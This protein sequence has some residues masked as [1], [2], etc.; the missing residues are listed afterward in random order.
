M[1]PG[2]KPYLLMNWFEFAREFK[3]GSRDR[4]SAADYQELERVE[5]R[6]NSPVPENLK[7]H[8]MEIP[9]TYKVQGEYK[10]NSG[11]VYFMD[12][13]HPQHN[14]LSAYGWVKRGEEREIKS[15]SGRQRLNI[16]GAIDIETMSCATVIDA[17]VMPIR[18]SCCCG[19]SNQ[20][21]FKQT[22][23]T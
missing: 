12:G 10:N 2:C 7:I 23:S 6:P 14:T 19:N 11:L 1:S 16:N 13:V 22:L 4:L 15:N 20:D 17:A 18:R 3:R 5:T 8:S 9:G 21:I